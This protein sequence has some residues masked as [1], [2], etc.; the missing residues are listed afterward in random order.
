MCYLNRPLL[1]AFADR[2]SP[3]RTLKVALIFLFFLP[4]FAQPSR[5]EI[6]PASADGPASLSAWNPG[7]S[8]S[9]FDTATLGFPPIDTRDRET[10][11]HLFNAV[12]SSGAGIRS[13]WNGS[14]TNCDPG[15]TSV[16]YQSAV[17]SRIN[18][19]RA[20]AGVPADV[21]F[22]PA[23]SRQ[24]ARAALMVSANAAI[25]HTPPP[26]FSCFT[27]EGAEGAASSNLALGTSGIDSIEAYMLDAGN[28]YRVGHRR[29]LLYPQT[30]RMGNG[31]VDPP[32]GATVRRANA[33]WIFDENFGGPRPPT[34]DGFVAWPPPGFV[35]HKL[36][37]PRWSFSY[38]RADF[39]KATVSITTNGVPLPIHIEK[40]ERGYGENSIVFVPG[41]I[42]PAARSIAP[43]APDLTFYVQILDVLINGART[44]FS[45]E[46]TVFNPEVSALP[47]ALVPTL[48]GTSQPEIGR[49]H[50]YR[51]APVA[52]AS[53]YDFR[54]GYLTPLRAVESGDSTA[55]FRAEIS[56]LYP[57][58]QSA[59]FASGPSAFHLAHT[60]PPRPQKLTWMKTII[61]S[62]RSELRF[63]SRLGAASTG[64][65]A[66]VQVSLNDGSSW[67]DLYSQS[68]N[69]SHGELA[70]SARSVP[71][72]DYAGRA[73]LLRFEYGL[74]FG[75]LSYAP[76]AGEQIGWYLDDIQVTAAQEFSHESV[77]TSS[78]PDFR[79]NPS[80]ERAY[81]LDARP[82]FLES[83]GGDWSPGKVVTAIEPSLQPPTVRITA[84]QLAGSLLEIH[85]EA[86]F[87]QSS[88]I[89][90]LEHSDQLSGDW[91]WLL[92]NVER[93]PGSDRH[94]I[95][96]PVS[97][98]S[99]QFFRVTIE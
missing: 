77:V 8:P 95:R 29:W 19:Y 88:A 42:S 94:V 69:D 70:F 62:L 93:V 82:R 83:F 2:S 54:T 28:N 35:P 57:V 27:L 80:V 41:A 22:D 89:F 10:V 55:H 76:G 48:G 23:L 85:F 49:S 43:A 56:A 51:T 47:A 96:L 68:G 92:P 67:R 7:I 31:D 75:E 45:Y 50:R 71:L 9:F 44:N 39:A 33:N 17:L 36:V 72:A 32:D 66:R 90:A 26:S 25:T 40:E 37:Y 4:V 74:A 63:Q 38:P 46:V 86:P 64:Q 15:E 58:T 91:Q 81:Y 24:A 30:K 65:V 79:F 73:I 78:N 13:E 3:W 98:S 6:P 12:F 53:N 14:V 87:A 1:K 5:P 34:R 18:F 99:S 97:E 16:A 21:R 59:I 60:T 11:R 20:L 84:M 61:P 52:H